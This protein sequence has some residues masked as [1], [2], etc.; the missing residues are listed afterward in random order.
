ML[1]GLIRVNK[2]DSRTAVIHDFCVLPAKAR[3]NKYGAQEEPTLLERRLRDGVLVKLVSK[4]VH[5]YIPAY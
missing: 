5:E 4:S 3:Q 1:V 2:V